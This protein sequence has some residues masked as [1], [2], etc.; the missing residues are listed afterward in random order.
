VNERDEIVIGYRMVL[1]FSGDHRVIDGAVA[2]QF[3]GALKQYLEAPSL[4]TI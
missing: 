3:L 1:G 2:A 4:L